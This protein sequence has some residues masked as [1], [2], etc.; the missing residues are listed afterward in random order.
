MESVERI[1][2]TVDQLDGPETC[3]TSRR[4]V[5]TTHHCA[6]RNLLAAGLRLATDRLR[7]P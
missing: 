6:I 1:I 4:D 3:I 5:R 7:R 2:S